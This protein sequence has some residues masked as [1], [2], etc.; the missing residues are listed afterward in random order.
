MEG[1]AY[2]QA[3]GTKTEQT[4]RAY[5]CARDGRFV[6]EKA[7]REELERRKIL[8]P[9]DEA[10]RLG[11]R[12]YEIMLPELLSLGARIAGEVNPSNPVLAASKID[13]A[14][15]NIIARAQESYAA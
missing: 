12:G 7:V 11:R 10:K 3:I 9:L 4:I 1:A 8:V 15:S 6:A 5:N 2:A 14:M 13:H